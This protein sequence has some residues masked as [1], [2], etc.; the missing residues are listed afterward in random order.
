EEALAAAD[1]ALALDGAN[2]QALNDRG[3][4]LQDMNRHQEAIES[5]TRA[6]AIRPDYAEALNNRGTARRDLMQLDAALADFD[7]VLALDPANALAHWSK[8]IVK[9]L[10]GEL[11]EGLRLYEWRKRL[12]APIEA[13]N[14]SQPLWTG[15]EDIAGKTLFCY[16]EQGLGD[17][18]L[19]FRYADRK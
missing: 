13:R 7:R 6:L 4:I 17:T 3:N 9:L 14:Y 15:A 19:F 10:S 2:S 18:I 11:E 12:A 5:Y 8:G 16:I 1:R